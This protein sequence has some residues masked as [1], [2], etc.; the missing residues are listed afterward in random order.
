M[1]YREQTFN[2]VDLKRDDAFIDRAAPHG[3]RHSWLLTAGYYKPDFAKR[4]KRPGVV[5]A[6]EA[7]PLLKGAE[8]AV[9]AAL[10]VN[11]LLHNGRN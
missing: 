4:L 7:T 5:I 11:A 9:A 8:C 3:F 6:E 10:S 1:S 2:D